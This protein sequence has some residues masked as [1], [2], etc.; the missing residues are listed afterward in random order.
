MKNK[1]LTKQQKE[2]Q[3]EVLSLLEQLWDALDYEGLAK[4]FT[5]W[6]HEFEKP[7]F[8]F[9]TKKDFEGDHR[10]LWVF[11]YV[12]GDLPS[13]GVT[14][15]NPNDVTVKGICVS[16]WQR[17]VSTDDVDVA[18]YFIKRVFASSNTQQQ[19]SQQNE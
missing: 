12:D 10:C 2:D 9:S 15:L 7:L 17:T 16:S 13:I 4:E 14:L 19:G 5:R 11:G 1:K 6:T 3:Q 8:H 18:L